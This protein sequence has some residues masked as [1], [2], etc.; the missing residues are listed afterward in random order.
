MR[1]PSRPR[2]ARPGWIAW[3]F[4]LGCGCATT[5]APTGWLQDPRVPSNGFGGWM[6]VALWPVP[7]EAKPRGWVGSAEQVWDLEGELIAVSDDS[8]FVFAGGSL[9]GGPGRA[10]TARS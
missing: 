10:C 1:A 2:G 3:T 8:L 6:S 7:G 5:T 4:L 9:R